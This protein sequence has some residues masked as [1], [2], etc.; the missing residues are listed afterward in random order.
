MISPVVVALKPSWSDRIASSVPC[1][2]SP[3]IRIPKPSKRAQE[4]R[5][6]ELMDE[7]DLIIVSWPW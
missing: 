4:A 1:S 3:S 6:A 7:L 2:P 5:N